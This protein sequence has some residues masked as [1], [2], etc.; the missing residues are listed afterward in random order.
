MKIKVRYFTTL[1]ELAKAPEERIRLKAGSTLVNLLDKIV[2]KYGEEASEYLYDKASG[3]VD[4]SIQ[5][6]VNGKS[7]RDLHGV[8]TKL[9]DN[10]VVAI[11]PPI[12]GG[13]F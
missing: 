7:I 5:F 6:L 11:V 4:P 2:L 10:D 1:R 13:Q 8:I 9:K 12:G 3:K